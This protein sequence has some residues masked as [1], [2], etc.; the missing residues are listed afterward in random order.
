M[1]NCIIALEDNHDSIH[2]VDYSADG[3]F[4]KIKV[5]DVQMNGQSL[6]GWTNMNSGAGSIVDS[7]TTFTYLPNG[8]FFCFINVTF[9]FN[10]FHNIILQELQRAV[11]AAIKITCGSSNC[12][13]EESHSDESLCY[14]LG[15]NT[16]P[17]TDAVWLVLMYSILFFL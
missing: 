16:P 17:L 4:Y 8:N 6:S 13:T 14:N 3:S 12:G 11:V 2:Y 15:A 7:G 10:K 9:N 1:Y 5:D